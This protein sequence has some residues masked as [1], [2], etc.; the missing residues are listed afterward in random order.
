MLAGVRHPLA[1]MRLMSADAWSIVHSPTRRNPRP[2]S[3]LICFGVARP[4]ARRLAILSIK[5]DALPAHPISSG[6]MPA[7]SSAAFCA[8][9]AGAI[10]Q[11]NWGT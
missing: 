7:F 8:S 2:S 1:A 6:Q 4:S 11:A 10:S 3:C 5:S 9:L